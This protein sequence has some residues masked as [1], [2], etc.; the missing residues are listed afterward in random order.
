MYSYLCDS[1]FTDKLTVSK[2]G[3]S[4][5]WS[6]NTPLFALRT[7]AKSPNCMNSTINHGSSDDPLLDS[8]I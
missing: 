4:E 3:E 2:V 1:H 8:H 5:R 7:S 6:E